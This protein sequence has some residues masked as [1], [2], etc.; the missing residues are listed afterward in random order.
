M[1][2]LTPHRQKI[3]QFI[4]GGLNNREI[5]EILKI[6]HQTVKNNLYTIYKIYGVR[7]KTEA[8]IEGIKRGHVDLELAY[9]YIIARRRQDN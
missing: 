8:V 2:L 6:S 1:P 9:Q 7:N 5:A 4:A 3:L